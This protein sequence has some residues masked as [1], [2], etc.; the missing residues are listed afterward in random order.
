MKSYGSSLLVECREQV[1]EVS[2]VGND[3]V[4]HGCVGNDVVAEHG[5]VSND[6]EAFADQ[7]VGT[8]ASQEKVDAVEGGSERS[9]HSLLLATVT[10]HR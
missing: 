8:L 3:V 9:M 7:T 2:G 1:G 4:K 10:W 5:C 6:S